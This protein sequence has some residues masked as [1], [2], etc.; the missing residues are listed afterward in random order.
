M[1]F[2]RIVEHVEGALIEV[3][4]AAADISY[5]FTF[6]P[7]MSRADHEAMLF[8][9]LTARHLLQEALAISAQQLSP[10]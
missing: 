1:G 8:A 4:Y 2:E 5:Q 7:T 6:D 10:E 3:H 9:V